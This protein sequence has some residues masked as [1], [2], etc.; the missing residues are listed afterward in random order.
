MVVV[1]VL[2]EGH[3][4]GIAS[5][6]PS[7][8]GRQLV[9][10][11]IDFVNAEIRS[12]A[13]TRG[14]AVVDINALAA[15]YT[16]IID[17]SGN[18]DFGGEVISMFTKGDEP[19]NLVLNDSSGHPGT[20]ASGTLANFIFFSP[21]NDFFNLGLTPLSEEEILA[22]AGI[23]VQP[24]PTITSLVAIPDQVAVGGTMELQWAT[25]AWTTP[26]ATLS[27]LLIPVGQF[28]TGDM[29]YLFIINDHDGSPSNGESRFRNVKVYEDLADPTKDTFIYRAYDGF[30]YNNEAT[31]TIDIIR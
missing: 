1:D 21:F 28:Y 18:F 27:R 7:A 9:T 29:L 4:P 19:H 10:D 11:A 8:A 24:P 14:V 15:Y 17:S 6:F 12:L 2:D 5:L 25:S 16:A 20:V 31:V 3:A 26:T 30:N 22:T 13:A 23:P